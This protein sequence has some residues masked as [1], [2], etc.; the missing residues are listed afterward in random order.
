MTDVQALGDEQVRGILFSPSLPLMP[1]LRVGCW[2]VHAM[3]YVRITYPN[4]ALS[5]T[6]RGL[7]E[8]LNMCSV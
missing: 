3:F 7:E 1:H 5:V 6:E 8:V 4:E 2:I